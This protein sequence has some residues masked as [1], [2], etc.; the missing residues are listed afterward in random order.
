MHIFLKTADTGSDQAA[1]RSSL[2]TLFAKRPDYGHMLFLSIGC[3]KHQ[4]HLIVG[5]QLMLTDHILQVAN[6]KTKYFTCLATISHTW[7]AY[8]A[9]IRTTW[10]T[11]H[12]GT[13]TERNKY[14]LFRTPPLAIAGRWASIDGIFTNCFS[15]FVVGGGGWQKLKSLL[16]VRLFVLVK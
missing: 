1:T 10:S 7:R 9:R 5:S 16:M 12:S 14:I 3:M 8:L 4:Y 15:C 13:P 2:R 11:L 6:T